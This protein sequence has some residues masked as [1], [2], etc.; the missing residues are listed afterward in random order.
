MV[1]SVFSPTKIQ[2]LSTSPRTEQVLRDDGVIRIF[3]GIRRHPVN[4]VSVKDEM[5][6]RGVSLKNRVAMLD[7]VALSDILVGLR[8]EQR[9]AYRV[10]DLTDFLLSYDVSTKIVG[11]CVHVSPYAPFLPTI[12]C[13]DGTMVPYLTPETTDMVKKGILAARVKVGRCG[14]T[15]TTVNEV[16]IVRGPN[17]YFFHNS[18]TAAPSWDLPS[19]RECKALTVLVQRLLNAKCELLWEFP[20]GLPVVV[21]FETHSIQMETPAHLCVAV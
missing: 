8:S 21:N 1:F 7:K 14:K 19:D 3:A 18:L 2:L 9:A 16:E 13:D 11:E 15:I 10:C 17:E 12:S 6:F 4:G 5:C 20:T